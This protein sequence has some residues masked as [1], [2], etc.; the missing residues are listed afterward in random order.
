MRVLITGGSGRLARYCLQDLR[1]H[2]HQ[3]TLF[4]RVR[5]EVVPQPWSPD[6]PVVVGDLLSPTSPA[7]RRWPGRWPC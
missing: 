1:E 5:P 4:D 6:S 2:G 3:V 7:R